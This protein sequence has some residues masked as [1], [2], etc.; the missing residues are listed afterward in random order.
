[1]RRNQSLETATHRIRSHLSAEFHGLSAEVA[2]I[3]SHHEATKRSFKHFPDPKVEYDDLEEFRE[4]CKSLEEFFSRQDKNHL[5]QNIRQYYFLQNHS[6]PPDFLHLGLLF[7]DLS[8]AA[9]SSVE[10]HKGGRP[11][12]GKAKELP[13]QLLIVDLA[14]LF[15]NA[16][17]WKVSYGSNAKFVKFVAEVLPLAGVYKA[18]TSIR[19]KV[20]RALR[21]F[22]F[23][24]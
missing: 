17:Q 14:R 7:Q 16:T 24:E 20:A 23:S 19:Q 10:T 1:M 3:L 5:E 9:E 8:I 22:E 18:E 13:E 6:L 21:V 15:G 4:L 2:N 11:R 12:K